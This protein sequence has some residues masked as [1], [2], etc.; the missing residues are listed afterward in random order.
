MVPRALNLPWPP[1][2]QDALWRILTIFP[3][4]AVQPLVPPTHGAI[5]GCRS[6]VAAEL[7]LHL[8]DPFVTV[9]AFEPSVW[10]ALHAYAETLGVHVY[11]VWDWESVMPPGP[12]RRHLQSEWPSA[13]SAGD[14]ERVIDRLTQLQVSCAFRDV[15]DADSV[16]APHEVSVS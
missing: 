7:A 16:I 15:R 11:V 13:V 12:A 6:G 2:L 8:L 5:D 4:T 14:V 1:V 3:G 9:R 10:T